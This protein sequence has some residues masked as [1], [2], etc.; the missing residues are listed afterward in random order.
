VGWCG[1]CKGAGVK[2]D[3][4]N[5]RQYIRVNSRKAKK[6]VKIIK[7]E[8]KFKEFLGCFWCGIL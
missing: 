2:A 4:Y 8:I 1:I 3:N 6:M 5:L 7:G